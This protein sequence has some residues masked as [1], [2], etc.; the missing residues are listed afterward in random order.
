LHG[1]QSSGANGDD[2]FSPHSVGPRDFPQRTGPNGFLE[3]ENARSFPIYQNGQ[4]GP[5][6]EITSMTPAFSGPPGIPHILPAPNDINGLIGHLQ[7]QFGKSALSDYV[8][9][10]RYMDDRA[11]PLHFPGHGILLSRSATLAKLISER[12]E[13]SE[14]ALA[15]PKTLLIET[16]DRFLRTEEFV[17]A[18]RYLYGGPLLETAQ[19]RAI[20]FM[21][22]TK[23]AIA[24]HHMQMALG[25]AAAGNLLQI[26]RVTQRGMDIACHLL[27]WDTIEV[28][29]DFAL[30]GG[31]AKVWYARMPS[32]S[33]DEIHSTVDAGQDPH[34]QPTYGTFSN[35][36]LDRILAFIANNFPADF[37]LDTRAPQD[38]QNPRLQIVPERHNSP[39]HSRLSSISFGDH[40]SEESMRFG[41]PTTVLSHI[42]FSLPIPLLCSVLESPRLGSSTSW[43]NPSTRLQLKEA[44][45]AE[46]EK[47]Q[48]ANE[49]KATTSDSQAL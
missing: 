30:D 18:I 1:S 16:S 11:Q 46:R 26:S 17:M 36:F 44:V 45:M 5:P 2:P 38:P 15:D 7:S 24:R 40:P 41:S 13:G 35:L 49:E 42:L 31:L 8:I 9:E 19:I 43:G 34:N 28:A 23:P 10:L 47:R 4:A 25:Y 6:N 14:G 21:Q 37:I 3:G 27:S 12:N 33:M 39:A 22:R 20:P 48:Q 29:L 32:N